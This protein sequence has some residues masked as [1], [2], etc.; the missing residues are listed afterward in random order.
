VY[1]GKQAYPWIEE[2]G[3]HEDKDGQ[4]KKPETE[5]APHDLIKARLFGSILR[6]KEEMK[7]KIG[8]SIRKEGEHLG[9]TAFTSDLNVINIE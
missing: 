1:A 8:F 2:G 6:S 5:C 3:C 9:Y 7:H 4:N